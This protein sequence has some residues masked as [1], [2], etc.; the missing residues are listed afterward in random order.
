MYVAGVHGD[1]VGVG[2]ESPA[3]LA[4]V[5]DTNT[6]RKLDWAHEIDLFSAVYKWTLSC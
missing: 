3:N 2:G 1:C 4:S 6:E 5:E